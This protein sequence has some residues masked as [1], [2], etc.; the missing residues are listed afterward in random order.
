MVVNT[1]I[2]SVV[3]TIIELSE[4]LK[5]NSADIA[6]IPETWCRDHI[7]DESICVPGYFHIRKDRADRRGGGVMC[8]VKHGIPFKEWTELRNNDMETLWISLRPHKL[9]RQFTHINVGVIYH[10][11]NE[12]NNI[13][14]QVCDG[15]LLELSQRINNFFKS[16]SDHLPAMSA[17]NDYLQ[18]KIPCVPSKYVIPVEKVEKQLRKLDTSKPPGLDCVPSWVL[19][20]FS[21]LLAGPVAA[22]Y[23][24]SFRKGHV[25]RI[26]RAA[27]ASPLPKKKP[28]ENIET[29]L[30]Q[31]L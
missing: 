6:T 21:Q 5:L 3:P 28:P 26:W 13:A 31:S 27:Y 1:N 17:N 2:R 9:P 29:D 19:K 24:S 14:N 20:E 18:L 12:D 25:P 15:N 8:F 23:K 10:S 16:V 30:D 22:I 11:P 7:P 4:I